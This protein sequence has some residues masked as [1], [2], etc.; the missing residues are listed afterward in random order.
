[1]VLAGAEPIMKPVLPF[2][3]SRWRS[4]FAE[5][6]A[7]QGGKR[8]VRRA[9]GD[10]ASYAATLAGA[11]YVDTLMWTRRV[12]CTWDARVCSEAAAQGH[13]GL[14]VQARAQGCPWNSDT[15]S[16][17][18][19]NGDLAMLKWA[20]SSGCPWDYR[21]ITW[22]HHNKHHHVLTWAKANGLDGL[23]SRQ[24]PKRG[25][26]KL[27]KLYTACVLSLFVSHG[28]TGS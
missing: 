25:N 21:V 14:L 16:A 17:A 4:V 7:I 20:R 3:C 26:A 13:F 10:P 12:G 11:G 23:H 24:G 27:C 2:V 19:S 1:M 15:C 28:Q 9:T 22:A 6:V 5:I 18:A 8:F